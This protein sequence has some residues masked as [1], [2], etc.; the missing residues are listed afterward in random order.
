MKEVVEHLYGT[1]IDDEMKA[2]I[3]AYYD[4]YGVK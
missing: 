2:R 1:V 3:D 4:E